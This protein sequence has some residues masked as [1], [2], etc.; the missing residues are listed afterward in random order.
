MLDLPLEGGGL[1]RV[2]GRRDNDGMEAAKSEPDS[3]GS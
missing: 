2:L 1:P 3:E